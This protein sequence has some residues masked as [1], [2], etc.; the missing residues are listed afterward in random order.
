MIVAG[1]ALF[2]YKDK[3]GKALDADHTFGFG[4]FLLVSLKSICLFETLFDL[5]KN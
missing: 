2:M 4:E 5:D 1:V 3:K